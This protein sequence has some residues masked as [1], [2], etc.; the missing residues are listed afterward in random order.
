MSAAPPRIRQAS[1]V[2]DLRGAEQVRYKRMIRVWSLLTRLA[3]AAALAGLLLP[4]PGGAAASAVA[5]AVV[6]GAPLLRVA[7]LAVRWH[8]RGDRRYA[9][10][11]AA[12]LLVVAAGSVIALVTR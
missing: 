2:L 8:R 6:V 1:R 7:W 3:F 9:G 12:L 5:V 4:D 11:A 10:V